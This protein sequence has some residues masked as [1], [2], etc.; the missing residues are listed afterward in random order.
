VAVG[1][2]TDL[3]LG[4]VTVQVDHLREQMALLQKILKD[5]G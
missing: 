2:H 4:D 5:A 3:R 1:L